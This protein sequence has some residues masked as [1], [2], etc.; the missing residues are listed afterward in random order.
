M[1]ANNDLL[2]RNRDFTRVDALN[3]IVRG[4]A[5]D[6]AANTLSGAKNFLDSTRE[7]LSERF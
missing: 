1:E 5:V 7:L 2:V 4:P 6:G 3:D